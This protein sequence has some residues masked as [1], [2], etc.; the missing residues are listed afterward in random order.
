MPK[1]SIIV[2]VYNTEKYLEKCLDS[3]VNQVFTD[4]EIIIVNDGTK[5]GSEEIIKQYKNKYPNKIKY[6]KKENGG[7]SDTKNFGVEK[8][9]GKYITFVDS[10]DYIRTELYKALEPY[11]EKDVDLIKYK[12]IRVNE[13]YVEIGKQDGPVFEIVTGEKA[14]NLLKTDDTYIEP[15][16]LYLYK[17]D[18]FKINKF[19]FAKGLYHEDFGLTPLIIANA[20]TVIST[21]IYGYYYLQRANSITTDIEYEKKK[22][23]SYDILQHYDNMIEK[24]KDYEIQA[25][26]KKDIK[27]YYTNAVL[28]Q[29]KELKNKDKKAY[30]KEIKNRQMIRNIQIKGLRQLAKRILFTIRIIF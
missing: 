11:M 2:P 14:F 6:Y 20:K 4:T 24:I 8:A 25:S 26:V 12:F 23:R 5:D 29:L 19:T 22:K 10:D 7:L 30:T 1:L 27:T 17:S 21:D 16:W 18:F 9:T 13:A 3:L 15:S 28:L